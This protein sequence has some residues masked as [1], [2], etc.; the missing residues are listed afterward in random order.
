MVLTMPTDTGSAALARRAP[1]TT[2][3]ATSTHL[4]TFLRVRR[5]RSAEAVAIGISLMSPL[6]GAL[7]SLWGNGNAAS[8]GLRRLVSATRSLIETDQVKDGKADGRRAAQRP[9]G[10]LDRPRWHL[11]R[12]DR[13]PA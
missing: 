13:S 2:A 1:A 11:Y 8:S 6:R 12:R 5:V 9:V 3:G 7:T 4:K 10:F